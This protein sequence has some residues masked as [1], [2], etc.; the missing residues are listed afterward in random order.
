MLQVFPRTQIRYYPAIFV[1]AAATL[2]YQILI[3]RFF[4]VMVYY[5]FA[6]FAISLEAPC[7]G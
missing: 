2:S 5:H 3:T 6:F 1:L 4:S 7:S